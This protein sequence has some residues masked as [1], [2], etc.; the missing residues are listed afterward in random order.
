MEQIWREARKAK[1]K[2]I[3]PASHKE[4]RQSKRCS[5]WPLG[6]ATRQDGVKN[7]DNTA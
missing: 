6:L 4:H 5:F 3:P 1:T 2:V 7:R